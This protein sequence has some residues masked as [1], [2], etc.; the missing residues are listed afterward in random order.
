MKL[1][2]E[3]LMDTIKTEMLHLNNHST[4]FATYKKVIDL[5]LSVKN[6]EE[7]YIQ[8][9]FID[10]E[11]NMDNIKAGRPHHLSSTMYMNTKF[12]KNG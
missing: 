4:E 9:A 1:P 11:C 2:A 7:A 3:M 6:M 5:L 10:G 8:I 12:K